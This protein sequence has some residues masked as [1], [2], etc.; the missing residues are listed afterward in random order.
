MICRF[1][2]VFHV[3]DS[4]TIWIIAQKS[5]IMLSGLGSHCPNAD[6]LHS[7]CVCLFQHHTAPRAY[8]HVRLS[9]CLQPTVVIDKDKC[10]LPPSTNHQLHS[11]FGEGIRVK[12]GIQTIFIKQI[13]YFGMGSRYIWLQLYRFAS[14]TNSNGMTSLTERYQSKKTKVLI[15]LLFVWAAGLRSTY[16]IESFADSI[17]ISFVDTVKFAT[18]IRSNSIA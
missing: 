14:F 5:Y 7:R 15:T 9:G 16:I 12:A 1:I 17:V 11:N 10:T 13:R 18:P 3:L 6:C 4:D 2:D 8:R